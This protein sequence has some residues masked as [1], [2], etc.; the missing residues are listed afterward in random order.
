MTPS[1]E[2]RDPSVDDTYRVRQRR[3]SLWRDTVYSKND[4]GSGGCISVGG[5]RGRASHVSKAAPA[6]SPCQKRKTP[7]GDLVNSDPLVNACH[8]LLSI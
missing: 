2:D 1:F 7:D 6:V 3:V 8:R 5:C 4:A